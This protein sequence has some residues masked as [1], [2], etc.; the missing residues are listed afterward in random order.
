MD[1]TTTSLIRIGLCGGI[2]SGKSEIAHIFESHHIPVINYDQLSQQL[3]SPASEGEKYLFSIAQ[4]IMNGNNEESINNDTRSLSN[5][6]V[7]AIDTEKNMDVESSTVSPIGSGVHNRETT[8]LSSPPYFFNR[9]QFALALIDNPQFQYRIEYF[10]HPR[11]WKLALTQERELFYLFCHDKTRNDSKKGAPQ[12]SNAIQSSSNESSNNEPFLIVHEVPLLIEV[13]WEKRFDI[14]VS[15]SV[16]RETQ[17]DRLIKYRHY[18]KE[19]ACRLIDN[20]ASQLLRICHA[21][22][23]IDTEG[24]RKEVQ[25]SA[26]RLVELITLRAHHLG[27]MKI[28]SRNKNI[29]RA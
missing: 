23:I 7:K 13:Q 24:A 20:Q 21:D 26:H 3:T 6:I 14:I 27:D 10:L 19:D 29:Y 4:C 12:L 17:I 28:S 25:A 5:R 16:K 18:R 2:A 1:T 9:R 11:I 8:Y 15:T 22:F